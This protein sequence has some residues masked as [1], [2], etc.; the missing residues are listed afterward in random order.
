VD[1]INN[2][3][4]WLENL[5]APWGPWLALAGP[6]GVILVILS[7]VSLAII[8]YKIFQLVL[9]RFYGR[10]LVNKSILLWTSGNRDEALALLKNRGAKTPNLLRKAMRLLLLHGNN[11]GLVREEIARIANSEL[12]RQ[13]SQLRTLEVIG[14]VSPLLGLM[15]TVIGMI[16]AFQALEVGGSQVDPSVLSGG[17]WTALLTTGI[18]LAV[19]VPTMLAYHWLDQKYNTRARYMDD[20][21]TRLFTSSL[22]SHSLK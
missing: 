22:Y 10:R 7:I 13:R 14:M 1:E 19:A 2:A 5:P 12:Q 21:L 8:L 6:V 16:N 4:T 18:G 11:E 15:G 3:L 17:I 20:S 9:G